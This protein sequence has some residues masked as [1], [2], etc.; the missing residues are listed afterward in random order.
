MPASAQKGIILNNSYELNLENRFNVGFSLIA[1]KEIS[2]SA[3]CFVCG[4]AGLDKMLVCC[5]CCEPYHIFCIEAIRTPIISQKEWVCIRCT[6]CQEC[7][8]VDTVKVNCPKC[9]KFY[10]N[11]CLTSHT[12]DHSPNMV[13]S[14]RIDCC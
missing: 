2:T 10:H 13:C 14:F 4:S 1:T 3:M 8:E 7:H 9:L 12:D 5:I 11:D 6:P